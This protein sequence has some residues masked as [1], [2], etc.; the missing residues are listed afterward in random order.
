MH[1]WTLD[2][3][4]NI[5]TIHIQLKN[6]NMAEAQEIKS[7]VRDLLKDLNI[8]HATIETELVGTKMDISDY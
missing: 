1:V 6:V 8:Q 5:L 4:V 2:G 7:K 3:E